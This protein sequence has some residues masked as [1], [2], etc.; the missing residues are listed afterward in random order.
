MSVKRL[1][2]VTIPIY[3]EQPDADELVSLDQCIKILHKY[4]VTFFAPRSL[5]TGF[6]ERY[7]AD[8]IDFRII[9][10]DDQYFAGIPGYNKLMLS[11]AFYSAF[12][13]YQ[14]ILI[15]QLDAF[16]FRDELAAWCNKGYDYIGAPYIFVDLDAYPIK[17]FTKYRRLLKWL[18]RASILDYTF[19]HVGNGGLS[20]RQV[21]HT[22]RF[23]SLLKKPVKKWPHNEDSFFTHYGNLLFFLFKIAPEKEALKFAFEEKPDQAYKRNNNQLPFGCHA[24]VKHNNNNFW[25]NIF[26]SYDQCT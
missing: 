7:C 2:T 22:V 20:L 18:N 26:K 10:F 23:L 3:K 16:V 17:V 14:Y 13:A 12:S 15:Y 6:Y 11:T 21:D 4:P 19:R 25:T 24:Y 9:R 1:V 8:R 5:N